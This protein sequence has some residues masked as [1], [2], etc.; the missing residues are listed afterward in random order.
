MEPSAAIEAAKHALG[1]FGVILAAGAA[2]GLLAQNLRI[3]DVA[4]FLIAGM[5]LGPQVVGWVDVK[6]DSALNQGILIFGACYILFDGGAS[7]RLKVLKNVW[8]SIVLLATIGVV[9][10]TVATGFAA[11]SILGLPLVVALL[12][13]STI[14][15]TDPATL[16][17]VFRQVKVKERSA[18]TVMAESAF[19]DATGA[20][21]T[22]A[23]LEVALVHSEFSVAHALWNLLQQAGIGLISGIVL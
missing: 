16:V 14:A 6:A 22:F 2:F 18:Q 10:T 8:I 9:V 13:A 17:P 3:P 21:V 23:L 19:I 15:S 1:V 20:I 11:A 4:V 5:V 12:L 7:L